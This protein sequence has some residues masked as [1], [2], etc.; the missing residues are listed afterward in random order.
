LDKRLRGYQIRSGRGG[1]EKNSQPPPEI[2][3]YNLDCLTEEETINVH[4]DHTTSY[5]PA[6]LVNFVIRMLLK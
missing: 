2:E 5:F 6:D 1:K 3:P 4:T